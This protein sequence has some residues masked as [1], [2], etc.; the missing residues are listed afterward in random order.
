M[1]S[2]IYEKCGDTLRVQQRSVV[3]SPID[4]YVVVADKFSGWIMGAP[5]LHQRLV[6]AFH[7]RN[8]GAFDALVDQLINEAPN[9]A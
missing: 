4:F 5:H 1:T 2:Q 6:S 7:S 8:R 9:G 3:G